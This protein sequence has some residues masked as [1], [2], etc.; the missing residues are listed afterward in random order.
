MQQYLAKVSIEKGIQ[1][2]I[3]CLGLSEDHDAN[4]LNYMAKMGSQLGKFIYIPTGND[5][6]IK[7]AL[8][9]AL[10]LCL[11]LV[12]IESKNA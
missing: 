9:D 11:K 2:R 4:L 12:P 6:E 5:D 10:D 3:Y 8:N 7:E 1:S